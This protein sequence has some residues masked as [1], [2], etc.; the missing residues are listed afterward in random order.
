MGIVVGI[1]L[2]LVGGIAVFL[3]IHASMEAED[4]LKWAIISIVCG[5]FVSLGL[6]IVL[7]IGKTDSSDVLE[8]LMFF[9]FAIIEICFGLKGL[10][11]WSIEKKKKTKQVLTDKQNTLT[12]KRRELVREINKLKSEQQGVLNQWENSIYEGKLDI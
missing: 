2:F 9:I 3:G 1:L 10:S 6:I 11:D 7:S 8:V 4:N 12:E 5:L